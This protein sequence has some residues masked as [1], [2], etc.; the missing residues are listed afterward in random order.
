MGDPSLREVYRIISLGGCY[1]MALRPL[2]IYLSIYSVGKGFCCRK[3]GR[4][5]SS[6]SQKGNL[7]SLEPGT[8]SICLRESNPANP[9][10]PKSTFES[11]N[12]RPPKLKSLNPMPFSLY[13]KPYLNPYKPYIKPLEPQSR[14]PRGGNSRSSLQ[15]LCYEAFCW[16]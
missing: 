8:T 5:L 14:N 4:N 7:Q 6:K 15:S 11:L 3:G 10:V 16:V 2:P 12:P 1:Y 13:P 9:R